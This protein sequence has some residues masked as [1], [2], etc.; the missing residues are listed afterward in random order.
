MG[1]LKPCMAEAKGIFA[2]PSRREAIKRFKMWK[3]KCQVEAERAGRCTEK[4]LYHCLNYYV[5]P[6][7]L[8]EKICITNILERDFGR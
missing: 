6:Q 3:E 8:W 4:D 5:F 7:E 2:A 1:Y